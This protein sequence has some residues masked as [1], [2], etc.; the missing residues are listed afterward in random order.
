[1]N[2]FQK[3]NFRSLKTKLIVMSLVILAVPSLLI[4]ITGYHSSKDALDTLGGTNLKNNVRMA[5]KLIDSLN[6][7]V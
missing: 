2:M 6:Q 1:M 4:G 7:E 5:V 3:I